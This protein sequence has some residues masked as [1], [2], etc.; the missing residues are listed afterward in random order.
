[1]LEANCAEWSNRAS[2]FQLIRSCDVRIGLA[3]GH[4]QGISEF[5]IAVLGGRL[6]ASRLLSTAASPMPPATRRGGEVMSPSGGLRRP[7]SA[8][9]PGHG[10]R[11]FVVHAH[12]RLG[13][14]GL[15]P[16]AR[17]WAAAWRPRY[18]PFL[19]PAMRWHSGCSAPR[20]AQFPGGR[21]MPTHGVSGLSLFTGM[22]P[23]EITLL[24]SRGMR[25]NSSR[26]MCLKST[27][28]IIRRRSY[29]SH[30]SGVWGMLKAPTRS[31]RGQMS[32]KPLLEPDLFC[33]SEIDLR[34]TARCSRV[35]P[36]GSGHTIM[37]MNDGA[38]FMVENTIAPVSMVTSCLAALPPNRRAMIAFMLCSFWRRIVMRSVGPATAL[39]DARGAECS[40]PRPAQSQTPS[41]WPLS[42]MAVADLYPGWSGLGS[43]CMSSAALRV[44][45]PE[46][47]REPSRCE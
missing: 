18:G 12:S 41:Q 16:A 2:A 6:T 28:W 29:D 4:F 44:R 30:V 25:S 21:P 11:G 1:M 23:E 35:A 46:I 20:P 24:M 43:L 15:T 10:C 39:S 32:K 34:N 17:H 7:R 13:R 14:S 9:A 42:P 37:S 19:F 8:L 33:Q 5:S 36:S 27:Q 31:F 38:L 40:A 22:R 26:S 47:L 3:T 45:A